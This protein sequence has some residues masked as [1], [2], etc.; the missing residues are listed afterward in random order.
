[1]AELILFLMIS[2]GAG[3][4]ACKGKPAG[5]DRWMLFVQGLCS[6]P[7]LIGALIISLSEDADK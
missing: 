3:M 6:W 4:Q 7:C 1:M 2:V 5:L